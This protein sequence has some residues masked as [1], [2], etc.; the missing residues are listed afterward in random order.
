MEVHV[1]LGRSEVVPESVGSLQVHLF[2]LLFQWEKW[3]GLMTCRS[4]HR[5]ACVQTSYEHWLSQMWR[6]YNSAEAPPWPACLKESCP[7]QGRTLR[8]PLL[9][10]AHHV[11]WAQPSRCRG[12]HSDWVVLAWSLAYGGEPTGCDFR[13]RTAALGACEASSNALSLP[14][15]LSQPPL[16][17]TSCWS[18]HFP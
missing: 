3:V 8:F 9:L 1:L 14:P 7:P 15:S 11:L 12:A 4:R 13:V 17:V 6:Q 16:W 18:N 2:P 5:W 10:P